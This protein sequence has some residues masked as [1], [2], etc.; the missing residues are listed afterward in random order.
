MGSL[1]NLT[2]TAAIASDDERYEGWMSRN[3][4]L[5]TF[6]GV[7]CVFW[8]GRLLFALGHVGGD[9]AGLDP[10]NASKVTRQVTRPGHQTATES[11]PRPL[12]LSIQLAA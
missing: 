9:G 10:F 5:G 1:S 12:H 4:F 11:N 6:D 8:S 2:L 3:A 7:V